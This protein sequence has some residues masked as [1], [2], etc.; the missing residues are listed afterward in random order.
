MITPDL[1]PSTEDEPRVSEPSL[2]PY[3][4]MLCG[5]FAFAWMGELAHALGP[6]CDWRVVALARSAL[7]F[8]FAVGIARAAGSRL[9]LCRPRV[10]WMRS[11]AGSVSL[12]CTF[13]ALTRLPTSVV[14]TLTNTFPVWVA[15][16]SWP[17]L[18]ERPSAGVWLAAAC[19][20]LGIALIKRPQM[21]GGDFALYLALTAAFTSAV[22]ML[23][24]HRLQ[25]IAPAAIVAHFSGV[26]TVFV[27]GACLVGPAPD[28]G[29]LG[30][31]RVALL[32]LGVGA[33]ATVGQ[34]FLTK[35]FTAGRPAKVSVVGLSQVVFALGL[36]F[37]LA[38][39]N[40]TPSTL[41]GIGLVMLPTAWVMAGR[42]GE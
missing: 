14:L 20:V 3:L 35:A 11:V 1:D 31:P 25:G 12:V 15:V 10:L 26:A 38:E 5:C 30:D 21:S 34:L 13:Y 18:R 16:L 6:S 40:V 42:G 8:G 23:G 28:L 17:L 4:W 2:Q 27:V 29:V 9:V 19:G 32:L 22:A 39:P 24:L 33:T 41:A 7:A 37:L 36:D